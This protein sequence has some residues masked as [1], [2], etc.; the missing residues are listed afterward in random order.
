M[1]HDLWAG[2]NMEMYRYLASVSL[3]R[4]VASQQERSV[5]VQPLNMALRR[6]RAVDRA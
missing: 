1:T 2:L 3:L 4:L 6:D 5:T